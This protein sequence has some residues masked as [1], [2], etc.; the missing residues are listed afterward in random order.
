MR[1]PGHVASLRREGAMVVA[2]V[3]AGARFVVNLTLSA[4]ESLTLEPGRRAWLIVK[5]HSCRVVST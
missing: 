2:D 5:T 3:D 4:A 1:A